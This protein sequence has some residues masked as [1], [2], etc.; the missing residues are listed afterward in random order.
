[1][2][3]VISI[4]FAGI[5]AGYFLRNASFTAY[6][7]KSISFTICALL[8]FLGIS[9]GSNQSIIRNLQTLGLQAFL[10]ALLGTAGS[11]LAAWAVYRLFFVKGKSV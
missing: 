1:M 2:F 10:L 8:F 3:T 5:A 6:L 11:V 4:M 9:I 7:S